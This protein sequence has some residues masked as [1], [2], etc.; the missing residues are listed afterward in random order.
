MISV[1]IAFIWTEDLSCCIS[2]WGVFR[3][4]MFCQLHVS[5]HYT[6]LCP[7]LATVI[8]LHDNSSRNLKI[9]FIAF[10]LRKPLVVAITDFSAKQRYKMTGITWC[11]YLELVDS[12]MSYP[13]TLFFHHL[14]VL[15]L[16]ASFDAW[17]PDK[18]PCQKCFKLKWERHISFWHWNKMSTTLFIGCLISDWGVV[19][20]YHP[21]FSFQFQ[22][23]ARLW[24]H[25]GTEQQLPCSP[26]VGTVRK[27]LPDRGC[28]H[29]NKG[30]P[31]C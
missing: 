11:M 30:I 17:H 5:C 4:L 27:E 24:W 16:L 19:A 3:T 10:R 14:C 22:H 28:G 29:V 20:S 9:I 7:L 26:C 6:L 12:F 18:L 8:D 21:I 13:P 25:K 31:V 1:R 2:L 23:L 15:F